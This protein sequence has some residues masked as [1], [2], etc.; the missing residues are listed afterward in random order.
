MLARLSPERAVRAKGPTV[1]AITRVDVT[2]QVI[3]D[4]NGSLSESNILAN[5]LHASRISTSASRARLRTPT[6]TLEDLSTEHRRSASR[7]GCGGSSRFV[8]SDP[9]TI[10]MIDFLKSRGTFKGQNDTQER[11]IREALADGETAEMIRR[12]Q[13]RRLAPSTLSDSSSNAAPAAVLQGTM[14]NVSMGAV[15]LISRASEL[16]TSPP[17]AVVTWSMRELDAAAKLLNGDTQFARE[18]LQYISSTQRG[19]HSVDATYRAFLSVYWVTAPQCQVDLATCGLAVARTVVDQC[20]GVRDFGRDVERSSSSVE[21]AL[22]VEEKSM[23]G[24]QV[25]GSYSPNRNISIQEAISQII[26][27]SASPIKN[28]TPQRSATGASPTRVSASARPVKPK[29]QLPGLPPRSSSA[30]SQS[31]SSTQVL[32]AM[33]AHPFQLA[34]QEE[35]RRQRMRAEIKRSIKETEDPVIERERKRACSATL[36]N[37]RSGQFDAADQKKFMPAVIRDHLKGRPLTAPKA[38]ST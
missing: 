30:S 8:I 32:P 34:A 4:A 19:D 28:D 12:E 36:K 22:N 25:S 20:L 27:S 24:A 31:P 13:S 2:A 5:E 29:P 1:T 7:G 21:R 33:A 10:T 23:Q 14:A 35:M 16:Q 38:Q 26:G 9:H 18:V 17:P 3:K 6:S 15:S 37:V 11:K